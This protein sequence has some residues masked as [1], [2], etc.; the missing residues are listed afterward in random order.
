MT[1]EHREVIVI[2]GGPAGA[3]TSFHLARSGVRV[4]LLE[5]RLFPRPKACGGGVQ[6]RAAQHIPFDLQPVIRGTVRG[7]ALTYALDKL[8]TRSYHE[9]LVYTVL[10]SEFD[11]HLLNQAQNAGTEVRQGVTVRSV[12]QQPDGR[13]RVQTADASYTADYVV[14][15]DGANSIVS[16]TMNTRSNVFWQAAVY[17]EF[18]KNDWTESEHMRID[19]GSLA[20]GYAWAFPKQGFLNVGAGGLATATR[21]FRQYASRFAQRI[22][23]VPP[24]GG[25][26]LSF[27]GHHLPTLTSKTVLAKNNVLLVGDAAGLVEPFTGEGISYACH[28]AQ[29]AANAILRAIAAGTRD[30]TAYAHDVAATIGQE[31]YWSRKILSLSIAFPRAIY[32]LFKHSDAAWNTFCRVLRGEDTFRSLKM[33][34]LGPLRFASR[35]VDAVVAS[36]ERRRMLSTTVPDTP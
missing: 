22:G 12:E 30:V 5:A 34:T 7:I 17:C 9:P 33:Q 4:L 29:L 11:E 18:P 15:A 16:R 19:W 23:V 1:V 6:V 8:V 20:C 21:E 35:A 2:G 28:S 32:T 14:G 26:P 36:L 27:V 25:N 3:M 24:G 31:L 13:V 10:R